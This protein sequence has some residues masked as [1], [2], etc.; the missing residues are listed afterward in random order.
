[1]ARFGKDACQKRDPGMK[2]IARSSAGFDDDED[3]ILTV[4]RCFF[5]NFAMPDS[6]S[7]MAGFDL[8]DAAFGDTQGPVVGARVFAALRAVRLSRRSVFCFNSPCCPCCAE[9]VSEH[10]RRFM[11][12]L[13]A[14]RRGHPGAVHTELMMLCEGND[15][16]HVVTALDHLSSC[17]PEPAVALCD[18]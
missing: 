14:V 8:A 3:A 13:Q 12:A 9:V 17:L 1:M 18:A 7:W 16:A 11:R 5:H 10:E 6:Q 2:E 4:A 15:T